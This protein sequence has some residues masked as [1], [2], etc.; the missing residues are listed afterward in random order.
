MGSPLAIVLANTVI[1]FYESKWLNKNNLKKPKFYLS[2]DDILA[3]F[4]KDKIH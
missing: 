1:G 2:L 4:N 3:A